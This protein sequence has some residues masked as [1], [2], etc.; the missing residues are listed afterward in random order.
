MRSG[1]VVTGIVIIVMGLIICAYISD[2][3]SDKTALR[4]CKDVGGHMDVVGKRYSHATK[5]MVNVHGC[6]K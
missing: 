3:K 6:V 1:V 5:M 2:E 4:A